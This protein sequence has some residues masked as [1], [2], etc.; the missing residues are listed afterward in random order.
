L[1][2][3]EAF[4][5][6]GLRVLPHA[7][8]GDIPESVQTLIRTRLD[9]LER[10]QE[11]RVVLAVESGSR[12]WGF[13]SPDSDYDVR[14]IY[15]RRVADYAALFAPRDVIEQPIED[16]I[17]LSGWD[18]RKAL[19]LG[20]SWNPALVEWLTS[21]I[22]YCELGWE[23]DALRRLFARPLNQDALVRHYYGLASKQFARHVGGRSAVNLKKYF[24]VVR[25]AVALLWIETWPEETPPMSLPLLLD[26]VTLPAD[27]GAAIVSLR[28]RKSTTN[29]FGMGE[30][31]E[32]LDRFC[33]ERLSWAQ[34]RLPKATMRLSGAARRA[35]ADVF[36]ASVFG[37]PAP[38]FSLKD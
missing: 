23:A 37:L 1:C 13:A 19:A 24:Y 38:V 17:D 28:E 4:V 36:H 33:R 29:E 5:L 26:G 3:G 21:P 12:A 22:T 6:R 14:F 9:A 7:S 11:I 16:E 18:L 20:L 10:D 8:I 32:A 25:P 30:P 27:V 34:A 15:V 2:Y 31:I 35:A